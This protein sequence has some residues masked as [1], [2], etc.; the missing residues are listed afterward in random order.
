[1]FLSDRNVVRS[2]NERP[3]S[4]AT[5]QTNCPHG[6]TVWSS[7]THGCSFH[8][9]ATPEQLPSP[10]RRP[11]GPF[12]APP[13]RQTFSRCL[14]VWFAL[15]PGTAWDCHRSVWTA[16]VSRRNRQSPRRIAATN[17][18]MCCAGIQLD[19]RV[20]RQ[21][22]VLGTASRPKR[23]PSRTI[24]AWPLRRRPSLADAGCVALLSESSSK[25]FRTG[26][27]PHG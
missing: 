12:A 4:G 17:R 19:P 13:R 9:Q 24:L 25:D 26:T 21:V 2:R 22:R 7:L 20:L 1:M 10:K 27:A 16:I 8:R 23:G 3:C 14:W 18:N 6:P 15:L 11:L 5:S